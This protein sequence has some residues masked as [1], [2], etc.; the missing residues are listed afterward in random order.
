M[1]QRIICILLSFF[2]LI[3]LIQGQSWADTPE[4]FFLLGNNQKAQV[5]D[6]E[7]RVLASLPLDKAPQQ[8]ITNR[9]GDKLFLCKDKD[10]WSLSLLKPDYTG[11]QKQFKQAS[12]LTTFVMDQQRSCFWAI[13]Q[14]VTQKGFEKLLR[15]DLKSLECRQI[16]LDSP[17]VTIALTPQED[18]LIVT[19]AGVD[20]FSANLSFFATDSLK[21]LKTIPIAKNPATNY[22]VQN[23]QVLLATSY[24]YNPN[25]KNLAVNPLIKTADPIPAAAYYIDLQTMQLC[26]RVQL[27]E[28]SVDYVAKNETVYALTAENNHGKVVSLAGDGKVGI[29]PV[30]F[31]PKQVELAAERSELYVVGAK[32]VAVFHGDDGRLVRKYQ[33]NWKIDQL[34][35]PESSAYGLIYHPTNRGIL[36]IMDLD[37]QQIIKTLPLGRGYMVAWKTLD[38]TASII[39]GDVSVLLDVSD[40]LFRTGDILVIP[41]K[42][43]AYIYNNFSLDVAVVDTE[44]K[45][46]IQRIGCDLG[47]ACNLFYPVNQ[48]YLIAIGPNQWKFINTETQ[49]VDLNLR[50]KWIGGDKIIVPHVYHSSAGAVLVI[51][52][53]KKIIWVNLENGEIIRKLNSITKDAVIGW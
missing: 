50:L 40:M 37:N 14:S 8:V 1:K 9:Q 25:L 28:L 6:T 2:S 19:T 38:Y 17:G 23:G 39:S 35:I 22:F 7:W 26:K 42:N 53:G 21:I 20:P 51:A 49:K 44:K 4:R 13:S 41:Q 34:I 36:S 15:I 3:F 11:Y 52:N 30:D 31:I 5:V 29:Y 43:L 12:V 27:G 46:V 33:F 45:E 18:R 32:E 24:G 47:A 16:P 10:H 48:K